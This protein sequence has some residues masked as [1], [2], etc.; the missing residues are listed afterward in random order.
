MTVTGTGEGYYITNGK[1]EDITWEKDEL[2]DITKY[3]DKNG[4][5]ITLNVGKTYVAY[6]GKSMNVSLT[7][8]KA[9]EKAA[10]KKSKKKESAN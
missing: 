7:S 8:K 3:Y 6:L 2:T 9:F 4:K 5:E 10:K 1:C